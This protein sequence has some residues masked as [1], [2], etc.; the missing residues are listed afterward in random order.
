MKNNTIN[1]KK[2]TW[3][4]ERRGEGREKKVGSKGRREG[5]KQGIKIVRIK[6]RKNGREGE[7]GTSSTMLSSTSFTKLMPPFPSPN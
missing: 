5:S 3:S 7:E 4:R 6:R 1:R 2:V